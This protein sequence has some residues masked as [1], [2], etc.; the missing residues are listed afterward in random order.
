[1][2][3]P[4]AMP[5]STQSIPTGTDELSMQGVINMLGNSAVSTTSFNPFQNSN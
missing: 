4:R 1:V 5:A 2:S 3:L